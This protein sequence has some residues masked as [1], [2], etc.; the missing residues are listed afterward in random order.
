MTDN[1]KFK[2]ESFFSKTHNNIIMIEDQLKNMQNKEVISSDN[3]ER[4]NQ[5]ILWRIQYYTTFRWK[6]TL[7]VIFAENFQQ[8][9]IKKDFDVFDKINIIILKNILRENGVYIKKARLYPVI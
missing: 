4:L 1:I 5:F 3:K 8:F 6:I 2:S 7:S 9:I